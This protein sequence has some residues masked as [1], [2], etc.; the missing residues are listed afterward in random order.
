MKGQSDRGFSMLIVMII[1]TWMISGIYNNW[2]ADMHFITSGLIFIAV[3]CLA[4]VYFHWAFFS[5]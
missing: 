4:L 5:D 3:I 2:L 1:L